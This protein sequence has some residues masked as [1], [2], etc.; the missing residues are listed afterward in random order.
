LSGDDAQ[1]EAAEEQARVL[2][3]IAGEGEGQEITLSPAEA[4]VFARAV[5]SAA[6]GGEQSRA[7][8]W[9][10]SRPIYSRSA[11]LGAGW[12]YHN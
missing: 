12:R 4:S 8:H 7:A 5:Q 2:A 3:D 9:L 1:Q 10:K 6:R 11:P